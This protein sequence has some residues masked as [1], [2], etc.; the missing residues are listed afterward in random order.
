MFLEIRIRK[1]GQE[2]WVDAHKFFDYMVKEYSKVKYDGKKV[3]PYPD[4]VNTF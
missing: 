3:D 4:K 2:K 1:D